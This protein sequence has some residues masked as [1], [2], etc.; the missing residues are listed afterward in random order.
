MNTTAT[1]QIGTPFKVRGMSLGGG[2]TIDDV[3][4]RRNLLTKLDNTFGEFEKQNQLLEGL[5][6]FGQQAHTMITSKKA[7]EAFD[8]S[9]EHRNSLSDLGPVDLGQAASSRSGLL[10]R[11]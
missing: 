6:S 1:P 4:K 9:K 7:R 8:I 5:D 2:L 3:E 11:E 10:K